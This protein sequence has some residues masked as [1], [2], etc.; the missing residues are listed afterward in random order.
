L[1]PSRNIRGGSRRP[2]TN[3]V[4]PGG[5]GT[6]TAL[7]LL[8]RIEKAELAQ[9]VAASLED[10]QL[11]QAKAISLNQVNP[12]HEDDAKATGARTKK[13]GLALAAAEAR[14]ATELRQSGFT[15]CPHCHTIVRKNKIGSHRCSRQ[16]TQKSPRD[17]RRST[18]FSN[19]GRSGGPTQKSPRDPRRSTYF[20]NRGR[21]GGP[22]REE[23]E[24]ARKKRLDAL[25]AKTRRVTKKKK[26][27]KNREKVIARLDRQMKGG[28]G[29]GNAGYVGN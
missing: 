8:R 25:D 12:S 9:A 7:S 1:P 28:G 10:D 29:M 11:Q 13:A 6:S 24:D 22:K 3:F 15:Q 20:S 21:S 18:Y 17:L 27:Q 16:P 26:E 4:R 5:G 19:R 2:S 23:W 14:Q